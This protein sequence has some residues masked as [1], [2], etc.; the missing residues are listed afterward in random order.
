MRLFLALP[1][2]AAI[3]AELLRAANAAL[4]PALAQ[5]K[6]A[7]VEDLH[8]TLHFLGQSPPERVEALARALPSALEG[9]RAIDLVLGPSGAFPEQGAQ[10]R[11]LWFAPEPEP[12]ALLELERLHA[13]VLG[14]VAQ[15]GAALPAAEEFRPHVTIARARPRAGVHCPP[16]WRELRCALAWRASELV[17][18]ESGR[19]EPGARYAPLARWPLGAR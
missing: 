4:G 10:R 19:G 12:A 11:V 14:A 3:G 5:L 7:Q 15:A 8:L 1:V 2:P 18:Y 13:R 6:L 16:G 9:A 17:L